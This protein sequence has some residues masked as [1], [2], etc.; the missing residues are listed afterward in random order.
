ME[1]LQ[2][3]ACGAN[4]LVKVDDNI[5]RCTY[6]GTSF[7][8]SE[9]KQLGGTEIEKIRETERIKNT[10]R[11]SERLLRVGK[12]DKALELLTDILIID[13]DNITALMLCGKSLLYDS[14]LGDQKMLQALEYYKDAISVINQVEDASLYALLIAHFLLETK[15]SCEEIRSFLLN[16]AEVIAKSSVHQ[17]QSVIE[18][19]GSVAQ[20]AI[21]KN[22]EQKAVNVHFCALCSGILTAMVEKE[23][24]DLGEE[25]TVFFEVCNDFLNYK[26][27]LALNAFD[28]I[29]MDRELISSHPSWKCFLDYREQKLSYAESAKVNIEKTNVDKLSKQLTEA[30]KKRTVSILIMVGGLLVALVGFLLLAN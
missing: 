11:N 18:T 29:R 3:E 24:P 30:K 12:A 14:S 5:Y 21:N 4:D 22:Y 27:G 10:I 17:G 20:A 23:L 7:Y 16:Q 6:C 13:G 19:V 1:K 8:S 9:L 2:C 15:K 28:S 26:N 25:K